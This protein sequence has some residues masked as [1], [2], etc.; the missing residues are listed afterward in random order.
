MYRIIDKK[1][2]GKTLRLFLLAKEYNGIVVCNNPNAMEQKAKAY[3]MTGISF[4]PYEW[5]TPENTRGISQPIF[6]DELDS[7]FT[8]MYKNILG[9][10][11]SDED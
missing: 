11:I 3:G 6:I 4:K 5:L 7:Y 1:S 8:R 2:T 10:T 9:Y